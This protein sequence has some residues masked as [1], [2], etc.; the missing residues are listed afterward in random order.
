M[1]HI[2]DYDIKPSTHHCPICTSR[3]A[4]FPAPSVVPPSPSLVLI[5]LDDEC[6]RSAAGCDRSAA[7]LTDERGPGGKNSIVP[8]PPEPFVLR[9]SFLRQRQHTCSRSPHDCASLAIITKSHFRVCGAVPSEQT[10]RVTLTVRDKAQPCRPV[11]IRPAPPT[12][13]CPPSLTPKRARSLLIPSSCYCQHGDDD[14]RPAAAGGKRE[15]T[16]QGVRTA[17]Q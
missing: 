12:E 10:C 17:Q 8:N 1:K 13:T 16:R 6:C 4:H 2:A 3:R 5:A 9:L 14:E 11:T 15:E 7:P